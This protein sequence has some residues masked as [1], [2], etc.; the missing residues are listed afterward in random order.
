M[1]PPTNLTQFDASS[2][3]TSKPIIGGIVNRY[4]H[5]L[6]DDC[7]TSSSIQNKSAN[8]LWHNILA[9][10]FDDQKFGKREL[11]TFGRSNRMRA[12]VFSNEF[13]RQYQRE[14]N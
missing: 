3:K 1:P 14:N 10:P 4:S 2:F 9:L 5:R 11:S 12:G 6:F 13:Q 7:S 8:S